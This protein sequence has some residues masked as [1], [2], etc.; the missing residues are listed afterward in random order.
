MPACLRNPAAKRYIKTIIPAAGFTGSS[1][2]S[3]TYTAGRV[4]LTRF[5]LQEAAVVQSISFSNAATIAGNITVGIYA[6][7]AANT[8]EAGALMVESASTAHSGANILQT[9]AITATALPAGAY[10]VAFEVSDATATVFRN[11]TVAVISTGQGFYYAR[12]GGYG[13]LTNP[14][15][16]VTASLAT[17]PFLSLTL[18]V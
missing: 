10:Y 13:A 6:E 3:S 9:I 18:E 1:G 16:A 17:I 4:I 12:A 14:C 15:P 7:G 2:A 8:P 5:E 11:S